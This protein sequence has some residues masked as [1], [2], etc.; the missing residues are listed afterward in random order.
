MYPKVLLVV[1]IF[2]YPYAYR[3][4]KSQGNKIDDGDRVLE[5]NERYLF[6]ANKKNINL[7]GLKVFYKSYDGS[8]L[9]YKYKLH[10]QGQKIHL[11][12]S[13]LQLNKGDEVLVCTAELKEVLSQKFEL[14]EIDSDQNAVVYLLE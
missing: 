7:D 3:F 12:S 4:S 2:C 6:Q 11:C 13:V 8:L 14:L 10:E 5:A 1:L 9:F